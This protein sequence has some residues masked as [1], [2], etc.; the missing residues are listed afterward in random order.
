[1]SE[2][3]H[4]RNSFKTEKELI[5]YI[6]KSIDNCVK[7][8]RD[9]YENW[10]QTDDIDDLEGGLNCELEIIKNMTNELRNITKR[11]SEVSK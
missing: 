1:M 6:A 11:K 7:S 4:W 9:V 5:D 8:I 3:Y 10:K 2:N